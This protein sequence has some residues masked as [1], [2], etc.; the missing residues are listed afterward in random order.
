VYGGGYAP[1][2]PVVTLIT[3]SLLEERV[4]ISLTTPVC[5]LY[6][7][8]STGF[9]LAPAIAGPLGQIEPFSPSRTFP[10]PKNPSISGAL[11]YVQNA[12]VAF[13]DGGG[14]GVATSNY[15]TVEIGAAK[16]PLAGAWFAAHPGDA[17]ARI[18]SVAHWGGL[19][20]R[21]E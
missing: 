11:L 1:L 5:W 7:D 6:V 16:L 4:P 17:S 13:T 2:A 19:A 9:G 3:S 10:I 20:L 18:A 21:L 8:L 15:R 14:E 12:S